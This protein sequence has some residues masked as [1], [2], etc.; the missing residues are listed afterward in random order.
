MGK[1]IKWLA[2]GVLCATAFGAQA[3]VNQIKVWAAA[4][5]NCHGT[6]G[7]AEPGME[8][9]AGKDKDEMLQKLM[10]FKSGRKPATIMHQ[11]SKGYTDEQ[12]AQISGYFA[13]QK[14]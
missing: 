6:N 12:L 3:Q 8:S 13:A 14:K 2:A 7:R 1:S 11:L 5:A 10:D 9:L 4:C